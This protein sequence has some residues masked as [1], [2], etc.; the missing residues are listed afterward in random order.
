MFFRVDSEEATLRNSILSSTPNPEFD[1]SQ[2]PL[3]PQLVPL[4]APPAVSGEN[5]PWTGWDVAQIVVLTIGSVFVLVLATALAAHRLFYPHVPFLDV[6]AYPLVTLLAQFLAYLVVLAFMYFVVAHN[7]QEKF[8]RALRWN[9]PRNWSVYLLAGVALSLGLQLFAHLLPMP[10]ELPVDRFFQTTQQAWLFSIFGVTF[11]PLM[12]ELFFRGFLYP[13]LARRTGTAAAVLI[14]SLAFS[15]IHASQL[16][17]AWAP[18]LVIFLVGLVLT[19]TRAVTKS[20]A[21]GLLIHIAYNGTLTFLM[22]VG[23]QGFRHMEKLSQ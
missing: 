14:T 2:S 17:R 6:A 8:F 21:A 5:P 12:E 1:S 22:F 16:G 15:L 9:W 19:V 3:D 18:V 13:V 20:V 11:A 7:P 4:A 10:K 23:T